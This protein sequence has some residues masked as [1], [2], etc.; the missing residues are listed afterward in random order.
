M[1]ASSS[2]HLTIVQYLVEKGANK[3]MQ[4]EVNAKVVVSLSTTNV[5]C[6]CSMATR[7]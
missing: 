7:L 3:D 1:R 5:T 6:L 2:G 4:D